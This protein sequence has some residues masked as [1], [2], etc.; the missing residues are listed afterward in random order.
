MDTMIMGGVDSLV[1]V[2][3]LAL[4][5]IVMAS[6]LGSAYVRAGQG[7]GAGTTTRSESGPTQTCRS[8]GHHYLKGATGWSCSH[9]GDEIRHAAR[10]SQPAREA[11]PV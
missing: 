11:A 6:L 3:P 8:A 10:V 7:A 2:W 1:A 9:C 5:A 4:V